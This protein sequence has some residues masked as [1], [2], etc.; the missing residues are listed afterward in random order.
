MKR[1]LHLLLGLILMLS[2]SINAQTVIFD[3]G[4]EDAAD[5]AS[6]SIWENTSKGSGTADYS[7]EESATG[8][9]SIKGENPGTSG[10]QMRF[11][12]TGTSNLSF[13]AGVTYLFKYKRFLA[14]GTDLAGGDKF[15]LG[16]NVTQVN[17]ATNLLDPSRKC[18][19][20]SG[21][22]T[23]EWYEMEFE[24]T[25]DTDYTNTYIQLQVNPKEG[26]FYYDDFYIEE[27]AF[28]PSVTFNITRPASEAQNVWISIDGR[29][30]LVSSKTDPV[31]TQT[32]FTG[33]AAGTYTYYTLGKGYV[34]NSG[35][36][37]IEADA[38][39]TVDITIEDDADNVEG[40]LV[41][42]P[43]YSSTG[44]VGKPNSEKATER[45]ASTFVLLKGDD[46]IYNYAGT[47][48]WV[49][50]LN[51][52]GATAGEIYAYRMEYTGTLYSSHPDVDNPPAEG[53]LKPREGFLPALTT[54]SANSTGLYKYF[55][56]YDTYFLVKNENGAV[57]SATVTIS[58]GGITDESTDA[59]GIYKA[60]LEDDGT[61]Y[62]YSVSASGY[63]T[64][65]GTLEQLDAS[66]TKDILE[67]VILEE[68]GST[69]LD[70][71]SKLLTNVYPN[72][73]SN[74]LNIQ[75]LE[76]S[77]INLISVAG[78]KV[79]SVIATSSVSTISVSDLAKGIYLVEVIN[80]TNKE[81]QKI[82]VK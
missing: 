64:K 9:K 74:L 59:N 53:S 14:V 48:Y 10:N 67:E 4:F 46:I 18:N 76:G 6:S 32:V 56:W 19:S 45:A 79:R 70:P 21:N 5:I 73:V 71:Q 22:P 38:D 80:G 55:G 40:Q 72:P 25:A 43:N 82:Q 29:T 31:E 28:E 35:S 42:Y 3:Q 12:S 36:V 81:V 52:L 39:K 37:T 34:M 13:T 61:V 26:T 30:Q 33:M 27:K 54:L 62:N 57:V 41:F 49:G 7:S 23:G 75:A 24:W 50:N 20:F 8:S 65:T 58:N 78:S 69:A 16:A 77:Q 68:D 17:N 60:E 1:K 47:G 51:T 15:Y 44:P 11:S 63:V 2:A 66:V